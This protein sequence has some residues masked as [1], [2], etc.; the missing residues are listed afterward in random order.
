MW[1]IIII[2]IALIVF[3]LVKGVKFQ[4]GYFEVINSS[5][6]SLHFGSYSECVN[7]AKSQN[8]YCKTFGINDKFRVKRKKL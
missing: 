1:V 3:G 2:V 8:E 5:G 6:T 4:S 7:Y